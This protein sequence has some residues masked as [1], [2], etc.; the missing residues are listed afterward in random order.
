M[1]KIIFLLLLISL[2]CL[3]LG[4]GYDESGQWI[5]GKLWEL[6][7]FIELIPYNNYSYS[8][9]LTNDGWTNIGE[10]RL[11]IL[12]WSRNGRILVFYNNSMEFTYLIYDL[13]EDKIIWNGEDAFYREYNESLEYS[14][15]SIISGYIRRIAN[16]YGI[17]P[18]VGTKG[19]FPYTG[20]DGKKYGI[21]INEAP[22]PNNHT[23]IDA[24][25]YQDFPPNRMKLINTIGILNGVE[26][27]Y[28]S[29]I[30]FWYVKCPFENRLA[31]IPTMPS[32][33]SGVYER[34]EYQ[35][36]VFGSHLDAG[37]NLDR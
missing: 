21:V 16:Q 27:D 26:D 9:H 24:Y 35:L 12:G 4:E 36:Y 34:I 14:D 31:I 7:Y 8:N 3:I 30:K 10:T 5:E 23:R 28:L 25:I 11:D 32:F 6:P 19:E 1:K 17:E 37:F 33:R 2:G 13:V 15:I 29:N 22:A 18:V 20:N